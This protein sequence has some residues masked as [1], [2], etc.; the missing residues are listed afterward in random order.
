VGNTLIIVAMISAEAL[1]RVLR[2][3]IGGDH[4]QIEAQEHGGCTFTAQ[5]RWVLNNDVKHLKLALTI[6]TRRAQH[7][8]ASL[9]DAI[10]AACTRS[11]R[12]SACY[13]LDS[14][15]PDSGTTALRVAVV[16]DD[17][18]Q[19]EHDD[20]QLQHAIQ[21][22]LDAFKKIPAAAR[23]L[24]YCGLVAGEYREVSRNGIL[25]P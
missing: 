9:R 15:R 6:Q 3:G 24:D 2:N 25:R 20:Q 18:Q 4:P 17:E 5:R 13:L 21:S 1:P 10:R 14:R 11:P 12:I 8:D 19:C 22:L 16:L 7:V 23:N